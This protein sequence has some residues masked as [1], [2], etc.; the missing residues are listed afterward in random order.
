MNLS[1]RNQ[2]IVDRFDQFVAKLDAKV[3]AAL[4]TLET[5]EQENAAA[6]AELDMLLA[7]LEPLVEA[8]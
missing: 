3:Q 4:A 1:P 5:S 8:K 2:C 6:Y 7:T